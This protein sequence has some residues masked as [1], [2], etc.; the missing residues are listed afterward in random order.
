MCFFWGGGHFLNSEHVHDFDMICVGCLVAL[1]FKTLQ[2]PH[3]NGIGRSFLGIRT[4]LARQFRPAREA[5]AAK[6]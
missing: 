6:A 3:I 1:Y 4:H 5:K 2:K